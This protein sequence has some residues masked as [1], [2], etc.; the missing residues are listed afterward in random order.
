MMRGACLRNW[1]CR[2]HRCNRVAN[3]QQVSSVSS[4]FL[5][6]WSYESSHVPLLLVDLLSL[7]RGV[8]TLTAGCRFFCLYNDS[9]QDLSV[10]PWEL[11]LCKHGLATGNNGSSMPCHA[12][13]CGFFLGVTFIGIMD[14]AT[15]WHSLPIVSRFVT[16]LAGSRMNHCWILGIDILF[17]LSKSC[18]CDLSCPP[19]WNES[20]FWTHSMQGQWWGSLKHFSEP[21]WLVPRFFFFGYLAVG[22]FS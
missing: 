20:S 8:V 17:V 11:S 22:Y 21:F 7:I 1:C 16:R 9:C 4:D 2:H 19:P 14:A 3:P 13:L 12:G 10:N 15:S 18:H 6:S 5:C